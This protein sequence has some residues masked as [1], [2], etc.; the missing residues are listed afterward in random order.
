[1]IISTNISKKILSKTGMRVSNSATLK[2]AELLEKI[3][4]DISCEAYANALKNNRKIVKK[5]DIINV[6]KKI[7]E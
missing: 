2:F 3:I 4:F 5:E 1:M 7:L 6:R